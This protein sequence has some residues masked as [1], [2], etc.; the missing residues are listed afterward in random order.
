MGE[1]ARLG[2]G[3][4]AEGRDWPG[5][6]PERNPGPSVPKLLGGACGAGGAS[7]SRAG[8]CAVALFDAAMLF[9]A[10]A[11]SPLAAFGRVELAG[12]ACAFAAG[13]LAR[14]IDVAGV[15]SGLALRTSRSG[16]GARSRLGIERASSSTR[17]AGSHSDH[18][19]RQ[20]NVEALSA[21]AASASRKVCSLPD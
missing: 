7:V 4:A 11:R 17:S 10:G 16:S 2:G 19:L 1:R 15:A 3:G 18:P 14:V 13:A 20:T 12:A 8:S 5:A 21:L 6:G 9:D